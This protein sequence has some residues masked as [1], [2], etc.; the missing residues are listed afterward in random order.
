MHDQGDSSLP[1]GSPGPRLPPLECLRFFEAA[2]RHQSFVRAA[3]EIHVT[4]AAVAYRVKVLESHLGYSLFDP[5]LFA[6]QPESWLN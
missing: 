6:L 5:G 2:A 1:S 3:K 4:P